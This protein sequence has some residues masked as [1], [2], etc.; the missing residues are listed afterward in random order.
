[1]DKL[2]KDVEERSLFV[3]SVAIIIAILSSKSNIKENV[4]VILIIINM[5]TNLIL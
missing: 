3:E 4:V 1:M 5:T 2:R